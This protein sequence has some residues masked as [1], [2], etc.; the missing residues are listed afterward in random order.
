M[1]AHI[2]V[3]KNITMAIRVTFTH[4]DLKFYIK[5]IPIMIRAIFTHPWYKNIVKKVTKYYLTLL[6]AVLFS[7]YLVKFM[8]R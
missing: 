7:P 4:K 3:S 6:L 1:R 8:K 2:T 5:N